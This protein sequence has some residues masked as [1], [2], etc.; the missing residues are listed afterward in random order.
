MSASILAR[1]SASALSVS[2]ASTR[3]PT[4]DNEISATDVLTPDSA[5]ILGEVCLPSDIRSEDVDTSEAAR[6]KRLVGAGV[7]G[8]DWGE[9]HEQTVQVNLEALIRGDRPGAQ[10]E[11]DEERRKTESVIRFDGTKKSCRSRGDPRRLVQPR[12][13]PADRVSLGVSWTRSSAP[14]R[15][16]QS[17]AYDT[18]PHLAL[19]PS[20]LA[21]NPCRRCH[22]PLQS[23][24]C[25]LCCHLL[26]CRHPS[27]R[28]RP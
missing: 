24:P 16:Y 12:S 2:G 15:K 4:S 3:N 25:L 1:R 28:Y 14:S 18:G 8:G 7:G 21:A 5:L 23:F 27:L 11:K 6:E 17:A 20:T 19:A 22:R 9:G 26:R 10:N 13:S